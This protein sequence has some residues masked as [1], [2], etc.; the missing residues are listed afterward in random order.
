MVAFNHGNKEERQVRNRKL[1][2]VVAGVCFLATVP[3]HA[4]EVTQSYGFLEFGSADVED[5]R[6]YSTNLY[7]LK[8]EHCYGGIG[9]LRQVVNAVNNSNLSTEF[10]ERVQAATEAQRI[11]EDAFTRAATVAD[12]AKAAEDLTALQATYSASRLAALESDLATAQADYNA[13]LAELEAME[14]DP[15]FTNNGASKFFNWKPF[16]KQHIKTLLTEDQLRL[17]TPSR[18]IDAADISDDCFDLTLPEREGA[19]MDIGSQDFADR[20][21]LAQAEEQRLIDDPLGRVHQFVYNMANGVKTLNENEILDVMTP[22]HARERELSEAHARNQILTEFLVGYDDATISGS[23][24]LA[25]FLPGLADSIETSHPSVHAAYVE[26]QLAHQELLHYED[27]PLTEDVTT[28]EQ[29]YKLKEREFYRRLADF[30]VQNGRGALAIEMTNDIRRLNVMVEQQLYQLND[31]KAALDDRINGDEH[32]YEN[33]A[34]KDSVAELDALTMGAVTTLVQKHKDWVEKSIEVEQKEAIMASAVVLA[35]SARVA[36]AEHTAA[37]Q[38]AS[39]FSVEKQPAKLAAEAPLA[40]ANAVKAEVDAAVEAASD[41]MTWSFD[42]VHEGTK[43]FTVGAGINME[44][45]RAGRVGIGLLINNKAN[46]EIGMRLP[47]STSTLSSASYGYEDLVT[48]SLLP[49]EPYR[50]TDMSV[51]EAK[52][53]T[54]D[55]AGFDMSTNVGLFSMDELFVDAL[56]G[57]HYHRVTTTD[58][59]SAVLT[60]EN[61]FAQGQTVQEFNAETQWSNSG[62][63]PLYGVSLGYGDFVATYRRLKRIGGVSDI[64]ANEVTLGYRFPIGQTE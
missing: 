44:S 56:V 23:S 38:A 28:H 30:G 15:A 31:G 13:A 21:Q 51:T 5:K 48:A 2:T 52:E 37:A 32:G 18:C 20:M 7:D 17:I 57:V 29:M 59:H 27:A 34:F 58:S 45:S 16:T 62:F 54:I 35:E 6:A 14:L 19:M 1:Y 39:T 42:T 64:R 53:R 63:G 9:T 11:A 49:S 33:V 43:A 4:F 46:L 25:P 40:E 8:C 10:R 61:R 50:T 60:A 12:A 36:D 55:M 3:S 47:S 41:A 24:A 22:L 26:L